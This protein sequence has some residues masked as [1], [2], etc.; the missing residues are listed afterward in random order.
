M[1]LK[2]EAQP[3]VI[4]NQLYQNTQLQSSFSVNMLSLNNGS[5]ELMGVRKILDLFIKFRIEVVKKR[6]A[7]LLQKSRTRAH[8]LIGL[9]VSV[10]SNRAS[11]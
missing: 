6:V 11:N 8:H 9:S 3:D 7:F 10:V 5:P 2:K 4:L 1:D